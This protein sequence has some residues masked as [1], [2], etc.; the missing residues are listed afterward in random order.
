MGVSFYA[1]SD[2]VGHWCD[3]SAPITANSI[4]PNFGTLIG[5]SNNNVT[6]IDYSQSMANNQNLSPLTHNH[7]YHLTATSIK[8]FLNNEERFERHNSINFTLKTP[9]KLR[10]E[11]NS[12]NQKE[13][14]RSEP[15]KKFNYDKGIWLSTI[16]DEWDLV[17]NRSWMVSMTQS[18]YMSGFILSFPIFGYISDRYGRWNS[19]LMG[20]II[21]MSAGFGCAFANSI[22]VFMFFRFLIGFGNAGR[23]SSSY[24]IMIEW[25][26]PKWRMPIST[27]GSLGWIIGY[28]TLPWLTVFF[29]NFRHM[30]FFV[31]LYELVF[32][33]WLLF[34]PESPR[35][36]LTHRRYDEARKV[37]LSA[38][39]FNNLIVTSK[40]TSP[41]I[42]NQK[43]MSNNNDIPSDIS[44]K[45]NNHRSIEMNT[46]RLGNLSNNL[47]NTKLSAPNMATNGKNYLQEQEEV[48]QNIAIEQQVGP[49]TLQEFD[50]KFASLV[51]T[52]EAKEFSKNE[53]KLTIFHLIRWKNLR[54]Y[55][56]I[57]FFIWASNSFVY[58]GIVLRVGGDNLFV[59]YTIAGLM[60]FPSIFF[61][62]VCMKYLPRQTSN[63][64]IYSVTGLLC[65]A[66]IPLKYYNYSFMLQCCI[67]LAKLANSCAFTC[68]LY[69]TMELFPTSIRQTAYSSCSLAGRVGSILAPFVKE[70]AQ[71]TNEF[72]PAMLYA[73]LS[74]IAVGLISILPETKGSD[75]HDT[76]M[77]AENFKGTKPKQNCNN[78][79]VESQ[80]IND[81]NQNVKLSTS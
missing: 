35:W 6:F 66:Q 46:S 43:I 55:L 39:K 63:L 47:A 51:S 45:T 78:Q 80:S 16:I 53:D 10:K 77:E 3:Q 30:Q 2:F 73:I 64:I 70:L 67:M 19:L 22:T 9:R 29:L 36:L 68:I 28:I 79:D 62:M 32:I 58:Y 74:I 17:C 1:P 61:A 57:L 60:E 65:L 34:L 33:I 38:A 18:L 37:L 54:T 71:K 81:N 4:T 41:I 11:C 49:L 23:T 26:G 44:F 7:H 27:L 42:Q 15:C 8:T 14:N 69:Q 75:L 52:I 50:L 21:E 20:A 56:L 48:G 13:N 5:S 12:L 59:S 72:V 24:L 40:H 31:G 25:V 76:L